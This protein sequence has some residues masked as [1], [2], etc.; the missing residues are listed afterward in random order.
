MSFENTLQY[1][2]FADRTQIENRIDNYDTVML[3]SKMLAGGKKAVPALLYNLVEEHDLE[4]YINPSSAQYRRGSN[5]RSGGDVKAWD[6]KLIDELGHPFERLRDEKSNIIYSKLS[7]SDKQA[8]VESVCEFQGE[9]VPSAVEE[10]VG[11]YSPVS[12]ADLS[13]RAVIPIYTKIDN[14]IDLELNREI[15]EMANA[16]S[17]LPIKPCIHVTKSFLTDINH[18]ISIADLSDEFNL[19]E[20]FLWIDNL[21][22]QEVGVQTYMNVIDTVARISEKNVDP[23]FMFGDF[24]SNLLY[25]FGLRGTSYGTYYRESSTEKT[26]DGPSGGGANLQRFYFDPAKEFLSIPDAI[27]LGRQTNADIPP[28]LSLNSWDELYKAGEDHDFLKNHFIKTKEAHKQMILNSSLDD[29]LDDLGSSYELYSNQ[30]A[31]RQTYKTVDHLRNW[32][33]AI[34]LF[35]ENNQNRSS[36]LI[37]QASQ[38]ANPQ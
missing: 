21:K 31:S 1:V 4:Y 36:S 25:Y 6:S 13:P 18:R 8:V 7:D 20:I 33:E 3:S 15:I 5:F 37:N 2:T 24:F 22:K 38:N 32:K 30:I 27:V 19:S 9:F 11:K 29:I 14:Y 16:Y 26:G 28:H 23:H 17:D 10:N 35:R 34:N 12:T